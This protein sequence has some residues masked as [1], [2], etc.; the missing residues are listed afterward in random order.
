MEPESESRS[1]AGAYAVHCCQGRIFSVSIC[2]MNAGR[3]SGSMVPVP[4]PWPPD[5]TVLFFL[6][7][8]KKPTPVAPTPIIPLPGEKP[9]MALGGT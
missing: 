2:A 7:K 1:I 9:K 6:T 4:L 3:K 8:K 5:G